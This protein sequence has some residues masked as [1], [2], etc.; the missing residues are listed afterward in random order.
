RSVDDSFWPCGRLGHADGGTRLPAGA[1]DKRNKEKPSE[2]KTS[3]KKTSEKKTSE[4][5]KKKKK[6]VG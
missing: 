1:I 3:E 6:A 4:K 5:K 2:K